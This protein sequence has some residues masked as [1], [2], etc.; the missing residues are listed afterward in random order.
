VT[1]PP[2][3]AVLAGGAGRR[4]GAPKATALLGGRPLIAFPLAAAAAAGLETV[5][6]AKAGT[7][8]PELGVPVWE[9]PREPRHPLLG[10][11]TALERAGRD[12]LAVG[13][14]QPFVTSALLSALASVEGPATV[15]AGDPLPAR[16]PH[17]AL[18]DLRAALAAEAPLRRALAALDPATLDVPGAQRLVAGVNTPAELAAAERSLH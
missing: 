2:L 4:M 10:I 9:E 5:V 16:W 15:T 11:V 8:L 14:D 12:V 18:A 17:A 6:V 13:C 1:G 7:P 3:V